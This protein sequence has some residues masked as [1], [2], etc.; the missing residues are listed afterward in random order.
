MIDN[1]LRKVLII[2][3]DVA[4]TNYFKVFLMQTGVFDS[5]VLNDSREAKPLLERETFDVIVLDMDM[6]NVSGIDIL[7]NVRSSGIETPVII[8]TGVSDVDLAVKAMKMGAFDYLIKP[9]DDEKFLEVL[10]NSIEQGALAQSISELPDELSRRDL[11]YEEVFQHFPTRNPEMI[12]LFH[13]AEKVASTDLSI[14][15]WGESGTGKEALARAIH[16]ASGRSEKP[17]IAME[18]DSHDPERFP[19]FLFGQ[20]RDWSGSREEASGLLEQANHGTLFLNNVDALSLPM[21]VRLKRMIQTG[22]FYRENSTKIRKVDVRMIVSSTDDLTRP[23]YKD[24]FSRDLLYHL[25]VNSIRI[26]PLRER[27]DDIPIFSEIF[28]KEEMARTGKTIKGFSSDLMKLL[29]GYGFPD[30]VQELRTIVSS[31]LANAENEEI[32]LHDLPMYI[33]DILDPDGD[34][35]SAH[36][37]VEKLRTVIERHVLGTYEYFGKQKEKTAEALG[38][39]LEEV[40]RLTGDNEEGGNKE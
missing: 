10:E 29:V 1:N 34:S 7:N 22:E 18:A 17:F 21:Q 27:V 3:D 24:S 32:T 19:S 31:A 9:V 40:E 16:R 25:M 38:V 26:P 2:D 15:I 12:K 37:V 20:A 8:L 6:P 5:T 33:R 14:F 28:L 4:V 23:Q 36:F 30:N 39:S 35:G 13:Q 11:D